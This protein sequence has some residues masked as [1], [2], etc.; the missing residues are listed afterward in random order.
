MS[1]KIILVKTGSACPEQYDA[2]FDGVQVGYLRM[3]HGCFTVEHPNAGELL[4][5]EDE[6]PEGDGQFTDEERGKFLNMA[7]LAIYSVLLGEGKIADDFY[8]IGERPQYAGR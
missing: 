3:R 2:F 8:V 6:S 4:I 5:L 1:G 7:C